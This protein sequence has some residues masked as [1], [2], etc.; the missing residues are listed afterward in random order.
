M[1][2]SGAPKDNCKRSHCPSE[3]LL[4]TPFFHAGLCWWRIRGVHGRNKVS[5]KDMGHPVHSG[6]TKVPHVPLTSGPVT[7]QD[8]FLGLT[9]QCLRPGSPACFSH[10]GTLQCHAHPTGDL[11]DYDGLLTPFSWLDAGQAA[12]HAA[13]AELWKDRGLAAQDDRQ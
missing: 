13:D 12:F 11:T 1:A 3:F 10:T 5:L 8:G 9:M 6:G 7:Q 4:K 2:G